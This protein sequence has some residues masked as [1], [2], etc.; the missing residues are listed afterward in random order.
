MKKY[1][2]ERERESDESGVCTHY[3]EENDNHDIS[4]QCSG[5]KYRIAGNF[6]GGGG[7][8]GGANFRYFRYY[9]ASH[10]IFHPRIFSQ[11]LRIGLRESR[12]LKPRKL[13][14]KTR[15]SFSRKFAPPKITRYTVYTTEQVYCTLQ[16]ILYTTE[17]VYCTLQW[18]YIHHRA[19]ILYTAVDIIHHRAGIL[20]TAVDIYTP[21]SRYTVHCSGY[22]HTTEQVYCTLQWIYIHHRA[23]ILYTA[24]DIY[25]PQSRYTVYCSGYIYTTEQV[26]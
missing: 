9:P 18:I 12:N 3:K 14:L 10:E 23:G 19:G 1:E 16:W 8:G 15:D 20:Y 26:Y 21:Q 6:R 2:R 4:V 24:V 25:T 5:Y 22:I 7:G 17:Q 13:I 11:L